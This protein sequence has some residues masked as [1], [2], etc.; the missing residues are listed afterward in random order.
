MQCKQLFQDNRNKAKS[1]IADANTLWHDILNLGRS[2]CFNALRCQK[3]LHF[4]HHRVAHNQFTLGRPRLHF[5][6]DFRA[7]M[8]CR[9]SNSRGF[10]RQFLKD[11]RPTYLLLV[12]DA[13][14]FQK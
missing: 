14:H 7:R 3:M 4:S 11:G 12:R 5:R 13:T 2:P 8:A 1:V 6:E 9:L 10:A